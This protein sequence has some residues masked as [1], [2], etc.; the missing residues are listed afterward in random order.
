MVF[1]TADTHFDHANII[2]LCNRPYETIE[3]M[4][5]DMIEK[6]NRKITGNDT[7]YIMGD[8]FF[9]SKDP[10]AILRRLH[11]KKYLTIGNHDTW[12]KKID[13]GKYFKEISHYI[14]TTDGQHGLALCHYPQVC[15]AHAKRFYMIHGHIHADTSAD[16][17]L[18]LAERD[19]VLNAGADING[20][21]PVTF[22]ELQENNIRFKMLFSSRTDAREGDPYG[23][24]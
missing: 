23:E 17:F 10:E 24:N 22:E 19:R 15:W 9:R 20:F 7:V 1:F 21:E 8:M 5:E 16:Y 6:W 13:A 12:L 14:V 18:L 3:Q 4:N 2:R 11:G